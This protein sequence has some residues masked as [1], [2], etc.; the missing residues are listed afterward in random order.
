MLETYKNLTIDKYIDTL[1][2]N[3]HVKIKKFH[4]QFLK[5][6]KMQDLNVITTL[7]EHYKNLLIM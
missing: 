1:N 4:H 6:Y 3:L 7:M 2:Q 5:N